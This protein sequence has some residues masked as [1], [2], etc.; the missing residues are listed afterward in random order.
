MHMTCTRARDDLPLA[1]DPA[2]LSGAA[3]AAL[4]GPDLLERP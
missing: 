4:P 2:G 3:L 1:R